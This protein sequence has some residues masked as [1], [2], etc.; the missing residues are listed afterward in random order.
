VTFTSARPEWRAFWTPIKKSAH[1]AVSL[2]S[3]KPL[4]FTRWNNPLLYAWSVLCQQLPPRRHIEAT[5]GSSSEWSGGHRH[6]DGIARGNRL[7]AG[8]ARKPHRQQ[9]RVIHRGP[10]CLRA[11]WVLKIC[12]SVLDTGVP[13]AVQPWQR[14]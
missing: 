4:T 6:C 1:T 3:A 13:M 2:W 5:C 7:L 14:Q 11:D 12:L 9:K 8:V 10:N